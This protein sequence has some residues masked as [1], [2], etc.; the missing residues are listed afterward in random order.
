MNAEQFL[1]AM[2]QSILED[3][4]FDGLPLREWWARR[5]GGDDLD[6]QL[7]CADVDPM[8]RKDEPFGP[9][10]QLDVKEEDDMP[11]KPKYCT[12]CSSKDHQRGWHVAAGRDVYCE[13]CGRN[14]MY[15][16]HD[17]LCIVLYT[18]GETAMVKLGPAVVWGAGGAGEAW[19]PR[20]GQ[21]CQ[22]RDGRKVRVI[23]DDVGDKFPVVAVI[24]TNDNEVVRLY[25]R[26]GREDGPSVLHRYDLV[27]VPPLSDGAMMALLAL[28]LE[29]GMQ[30][31]VTPRPE[32]ITG[33][34]WY[35][36]DGCD[37]GSEPRRMIKWMADRLGAKLWRD[38]W[39]KMS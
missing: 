19:R 18:G 3:W 2:R 20:V 24:T 7:G 27:P 13:S 14:I 29:L 37:F 39:R 33:L 10:D 16:N 34:N 5:Y 36:P 31:T 28:E 6:L 1:D 35:S 38:G 17:P 22:T 11:P 15:G 21:P 8:S 4:R 30:F 9:A 23:A 26:D 25:R 32:R 12:I